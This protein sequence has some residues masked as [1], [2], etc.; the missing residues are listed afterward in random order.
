MEGLEP[1]LTDEEL[2]LIEGRAQVSPDLSLSRDEVTLLHRGEAIAGSVTEPSAA[3]LILNAKQD[4]LRLA[5]E[6]RR[7]RARLAERA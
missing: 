7:L 4:V 2:A 6:V 3:P 5:A 1:E